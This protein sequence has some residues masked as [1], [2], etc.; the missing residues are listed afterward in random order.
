MKPG[1]QLLPG[2]ET[3]HPSKVSKYNQTAGG[4]FLW[5]TTTPH[6]A[7]RWGTHVYEVKHEGLVN[8]IEGGADPDPH[9]SL[10]AKVVRRVPKE[11]I[12]ASRIAHGEK[13]GHPDVHPTDANKGMVTSKA[14]R[15]L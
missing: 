14:R 13:Y 10:G 5:T 6:W 11:E 4:E 9:F 12:T 15:A 3:V 2:N 7:D 1:D 8:P